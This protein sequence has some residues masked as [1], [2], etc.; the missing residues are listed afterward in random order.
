MRTFLFLAAI[1]FVV[2]FILL[3]TDASPQTNTKLKNGSSSPG[4]ADIVFLDAISVALQRIEPHFQ[5]IGVEEETPEEIVEETAKENMP[6]FGTGTFG[7]RIFFVLF[8]TRTVFAL[9]GT[10]TIRHSDFR[11]SDHSALGPVAAE[12]NADLTLQNQWDSKACD[13][14]LALSEFNQ[15]VQNNGKEMGW[16]SVFAEH[17]ISKNLYYEVKVLNIGYNISIGLATREMPLKKNVVGD[18]KGSYGYDDNGTL[19][20][21]AVEVKSTTKRT[22]ASSNGK[23]LVFAETAP[24]SV[25]FAIELSELFPCISLYHSGTE[26]KAN[27]GPDFEYK[28]NSPDY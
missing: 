23:L 9:F 12:P 6:L 19:W 4:N 28:G 15:I 20:A 21:D 24:L 16:R 5:A 17:P 18:N 1:C 3:L 22:F 10:R 11:Y 26:I 13:E 27:F 8:G 25:D 14:D 7:T 2:A